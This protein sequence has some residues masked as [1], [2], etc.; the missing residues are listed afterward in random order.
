VNISLNTEFAVVTL[1]L[2]VKTRYST[3]KAKSAFS[4]MLD[5][6]VTLNFDLLTPKLEAFILV[7]KCTNAESLVKIRPILFKILC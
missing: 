7:P 3:N 5:P 4:S 2:L 6:I 1:T